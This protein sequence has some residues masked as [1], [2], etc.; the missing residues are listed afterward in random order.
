MKPCLTLSLVPS[1]RGGPWVLWDD[2]STGIRKTSELGF[3]AI[4]LFTEGPS[5]GNPGELGKVLRQNNLELG[6]VGTGAGKVIKGLTL[7]DP[8]PVIRQK[9]IDF[10]EEMIDFGAEHQAPAI[11]GS[12]QG[13]SSEA[14]GRDDCLKW[15]GEALVQLGEKAK[16]AGTFLIYE[17]LNRY[18][19]NLF[20][21]FGDAS[22]FLDEL[23]VQGVTLLA[24]LFHMNIEEANIPE[25]LREGSRYVGHVHF[26]DSNR[27]PVGFGHTDMKPIAEALIEIGY[28]SCVS[29]E[30]FDWPDPDTA[31]QKTIES[32]RKYFS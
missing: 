15:L 13:S 25:A 28:N 5:A 23:K 11:I 7:T 8:N 3:S 22:V 24:D 1:L 6:A 30:A 4:E 12:M 10:I 26:A 19:T 29:A 9:A 17:P 21:R 16:G 31:A 20:N 27:R 32:Y 14:A 2:L 18:E